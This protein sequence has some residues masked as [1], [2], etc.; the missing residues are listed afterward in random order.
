[1][2]SKWIAGAFDGDSNSGMDHGSLVDCLLL[3]PD[4]YEHSYSVT[5]ETYPAKG[6]RK[7]DPEEQKPWT[8]KAGYC[9]EWEDGIR[10]EGKQPIQPVQLNSANAAIRRLNED[11]VIADWVANSDKQVFFQVKWRDEETGITIP[12]KGLID[13]VPRATIAGIKALSLGDLKTSRDANLRAYSKSVF[14]NGYHVQSAL[15]LD[16]YNIVTGEQ[17]NQF[18]HIISE[19]ES[20][21]ECCKRWLSEEFID[22]GRTTYQAI[23]RQYCQCLSTNHWPGYD[24]WG[25]ET[26]IDGWGCISPAAWM[27]LES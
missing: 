26:S 12:M 17:R 10:T 25:A 7:D 14:E 2:P 3:T 15:Y 22:L 20:P 11:V 8:L 23:L 19:N 13:L 27:I 1:L 9:K 16:C 5:P 6:K 24:E 18:R 21:F 4:E